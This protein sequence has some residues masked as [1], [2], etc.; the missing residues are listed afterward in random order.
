MLNQFDTYEELLTTSDWGAEA[1]L[2]ILKLMDKS[3]GFTKEDFCKMARDC[4]MPPR[5]IARYFRIKIGEFEGAGYIER[6]VG[7][8]GWTPVWRKVGIHGLTCI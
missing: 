1:E 6:T 8:D 2:I 4:P 3:K 5:M 7:Q